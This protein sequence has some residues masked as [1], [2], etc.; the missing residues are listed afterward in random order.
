MGVY[1]EQAQRTYKFDSILGG[2]EEVLMDLGVRQ[3]SKYMPK[4]VL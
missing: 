4:A 1:I 3:A 2:S